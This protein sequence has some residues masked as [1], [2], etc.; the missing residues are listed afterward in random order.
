MA[1]IYLQ[2]LK[3]RPYVKT[4]ADVL[5]A[6]NY[7]IGN[8]RKWAV[9]NGKYLPLSK[10]DLEKY[11]PEAILE[12]FNEGLKLYALDIM[13]IVNEWLIKSGFADGGYTKNIGVNQ[14]AGV[15]HGGEWVAPA[16]LLKRYPGL[17]AQLEGIRK[18]GYQEGGY[19][20]TNTDTALFEPIEI[21]KDD[22]KI[23]TWAENIERSL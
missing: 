13:Q 2:Y 18:R 15:V 1:L 7:G 22:E 14:I 20:E 8:Y 21:P 5:S 4:L 9:S 12:N 19:V 10:R 11:S 3:E 16:W 23:E 6:W 17:I